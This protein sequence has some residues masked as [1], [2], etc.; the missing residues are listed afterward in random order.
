MSW[1]VEDRKG[2]VHEIAADER[3]L[4]IA[5]NENTARNWLLENNLPP[6]GSQFTCADDWR[7][8]SGGNWRVVLWLEGRQFNPEIA[9]FERSVGYLKKK[10]GANRVRDIYA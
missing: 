3:V 5:L 6:F 1:L 8:I 9:N 10:L 4:I 2:E 7:F